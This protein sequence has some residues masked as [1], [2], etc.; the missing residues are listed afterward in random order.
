[1]LRKARRI[2]P[3]ETCITLYNA[4]ILP[5]FDYCCSIWD[6][7]GKPNCDF[8]DKLQRRAATIIEGSRIRQC[9]INLTFSWPSLQSRRTYQICLQ[10]FK[11]LNGLAPAYL[12]HE[13][14]FANEIHAYNTRN[15]DLLR[16]PLARTKKYQGSFRYNGA[17]TWNL[18]PSSFRNETRFSKFKID[19]K[20][21]LKESSFNT[22]YTLS[23]Q[24]VC[25]YL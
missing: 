14:R 2:L 18:L 19:L 7:Y 17:K 4:M 23:Y 15:R 9:G 5:L 11:C 12:L 20:K 13:F 10:V 22:L 3:L 24:I 8:L 21:F 16:L 1:M 25:K 6:S